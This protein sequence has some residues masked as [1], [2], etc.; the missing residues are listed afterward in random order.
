M[1]KLQSRFNLILAAL[2][3]VV[4]VNNAHAALNLTKVQVIDPNS[5]D[6][7]FDG[8]IQPGQIRT[9]FVRDNIQLTLEDVAVYPAKVSML[10]G[11]EMTKIFAYQY[12][13]KTVRARFTVK[14]DALTYSKRLQV[15]ANGKII[16]LRVGAPSKKDAVT[17]S[18]AAPVRQAPA[19][20]SSAQAA[21][22]SVPT[23]ASKDLLERVTAAQKEESSEKNAEKAEIAKSDKQ[24]SA[25]AE[26][27]PLGIGRKE[28][29]SKKPLAGGA[30]LPTPF[31]SIGVMLFILGLLGIFALFMKKAKNGQANKLSSF[32]GKFSGQNG[33]KNLIQVVGSHSLGPKKSIMM[34][35]IQDRTLVL[36]LTEDSVNLITELRSG[37]MDGDESIDVGDFASSLKKFENDS[38]PKGPSVQLKPNSKLGDLAAAAMGLGSKKAATEQPAPQSRPAQPSGA[39]ALPAGPSATVS[40]GATKLAAQNAYSQSTP[41][42]AAPQA[43]SQGTGRADVRA[44]IKNRIEGMKQL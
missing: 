16:S 35:K 12:S 22:V 30:S 5:I 3:A 21:A 26:S 37:E 29:A 34:V 13:P 39:Y 7:I 32:L 11:G 23:T 9:E 20:E 8:K 33:A 42:A 15:R 24:E 31:R 18:Q 1:R 40:L 43:S 27:K 19:I 25:K 6:L 41:R 14:G 38:L 2:V 10:S 4:G 44:Q 17:V 36:G 28:A